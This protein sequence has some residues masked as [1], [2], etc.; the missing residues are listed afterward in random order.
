MVA[1][2]VKNET[3][4]GHIREL[5]LPVGSLD[6]HLVATLGHPFSRRLVATLGRRVGRHTWSPFS[7][8]FQSP[9]RRHLV[10]VWSPLGRHLASPFG[11]HLVNRLVATWSP[12]GR[13]LIATW[14]P[15]WSSAGRAHSGLMCRC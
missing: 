6:V 12:L 1:R 14:L 9:P 15:V 3:E 7:R 10:A 13:L 11:R 8:R 5:R 4:G 2:E